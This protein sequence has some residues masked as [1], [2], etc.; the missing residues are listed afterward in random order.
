MRDVRGGAAAVHRSDHR[1]D[2]GF[3]VRNAS[4]QP[5]ATGLEVDRPLTRP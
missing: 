3:G 1:K 2:P 4:A 5:C